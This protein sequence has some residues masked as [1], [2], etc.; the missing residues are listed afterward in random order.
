MDGKPHPAGNMPGAATVR[1][2]GDIAYL[3]SA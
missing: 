2:A 1:A 3:Q